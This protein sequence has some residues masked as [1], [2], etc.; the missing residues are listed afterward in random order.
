MNCKHY[1]NFKYDILID[2]S[3]ELTIGINYSAENMH[4]FVAQTYD[5]TDQEAQRQLHI[6]LTELD[7]A[8]RI[9]NELLER[10]RETH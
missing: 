6:V 7:Q 3:Y 10:Y 9:H 2:V 5:R 8:R 4:R 1:F